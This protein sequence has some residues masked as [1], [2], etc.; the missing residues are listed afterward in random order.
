MPCPWEAVSAFCWSFALPPADSPVCPSRGPGLP[1]AL[2]AG[3]C[4]RRAA[5]GWWGWLSAACL[6]PATRARCCG[7]GRRPTRAIAKNRKEQEEEK[8]SWWRGSRWWL[9]P[10]TGQAEPLVPG[11]VTASPLGLLERTVHSGRQMEA[12]LHLPGAPA[13]QGLAQ[14]KTL[15]HLNPVAES[16]KAWAV[17]APKSLGWERVC[18]SLFPGPPQP[19]SSP[20][21]RASL[22]S[23]PRRP[24]TPQAS[25]SL[26]WGPDL[27][28]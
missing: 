10:D 7:T 8:R 6:T 11:A 9:P 12:A 15:I 5:Q 27:T 26:A 20:H 21:A 25:L 13:L 19:S 16:G 14:G 28:P 23:S 22:P 18:W 24:A 3:A 17:G 2:G 4:C 1:L